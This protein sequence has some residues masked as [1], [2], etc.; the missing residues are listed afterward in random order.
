MTAECGKTGVLATRYLLIAA[1]IAWEIWLVHS[2][3]TLAS[4]KNAPKARTDRQEVL[5]TVLPLL[6]H[7][8]GRLSET[9]WRVGC[10]S[11]CCIC[12]TARAVLSATLCA[13]LSWLGA[14]LARQLTSTACAQSFATLACLCATTC[15][16]L[17]FLAELMTFLLLQ[18]QQQ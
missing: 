13:Y 10:H 3:L 15:I 2:L 14:F 4:A 16:S 6:L 8:H 17:W 11:T 7:R 5:L 12:A 1:R 9:R 18:T